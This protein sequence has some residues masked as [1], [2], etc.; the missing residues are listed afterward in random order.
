MR[1]GRSCRGAVPVKLAGCCH[2]GVARPGMFYRLAL[3]LDNSVT[4]KDVNDLTRRVR[5]P[6]CT[7][8]VGK[9]GEEHLRSDRFTELADKTLS[10][11]AGE[12]IRRMAQLSLEF[13]TR[14]DDLHSLESSSLRIR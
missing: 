1:R 12:Q 3:D 13:L 10:Y 11:L 4:G 14:S 8:S 5:V 2:D 7:G 9:S 6:V